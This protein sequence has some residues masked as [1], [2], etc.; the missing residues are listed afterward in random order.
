MSV[1]ILVNRDDDQAALYC[2]TTE[3]AFG[4]LFGSEQEAEAFLGWAHEE[5][6]GAGLRN[7]E[8]S[9]LETFVSQF[10]GLYRECEDC[11]DSFFVEFSVDR[12]T[13]KCGDC[14]EREDA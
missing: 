4:P 1:R 10:R 13:L 2:S 14:R 3:W 8:P 9:N 12:E 7:L 5:C 11:G 6:P